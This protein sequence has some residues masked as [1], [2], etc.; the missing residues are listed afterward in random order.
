MKK[1]FLLVA[2]LCVSTVSFSQN[3]FSLFNKA[4]DFF[5]LLGEAKFDSAH[6]YFDESEQTKITADNLKQ[7]WTNMTTALGKPES[8]EAVQS[9][10]QDGFFAVTMEGKFANAD[11][12]FIIAFNKEEKIIGLLVA[13]KAATYLVPSYAADTTKYQEQSTYVQTPGHQLAAVVTTPRN[14]TNF[15]MVVLVHGS[16]SGDMDETVGPNKPF[17]DI[18]LG[19]ASKG[20]GSIR[21]VKRSLVY[22]GEFNKAFTVK[23]EVIDD[24]VAALAM[25]KTIKGVDQKNIYLFGHN[26]GGMLAPQIAA[27]VSSLNGVIL[28]ATPARKLTD[29]IIS[30]N[31]YFF[32]KIK[33]TTAAAKSQ[34]QA[35]VTEV[36]KSRISKLG[37]LKP[38]SSIIGL[39]A[40]YW[41]NLNAYDQ[42]NAVKKLN[43]R[44]LILQGGYDFQVPELDFNLWKAALVQ[45]KNASFKLYPTL[46]HLLSPQTEIGTSAQYQ[47]LTNVSEDLINDIALWI[48]GQPL[49]K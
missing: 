22:A 8:I 36:E 4:N 16:G 21:Y 34:L 43:K 45:K 17:K 32:D 26:L 6:L 29:L 12:N 39:P 19:L 9:K 41:V 33:D 23:E 35:M 47:I 48:K 46:N 7:F 49:N 24:A 31:Q 3:V 18:A 42:V 13:P 38:D 20:I 5:T 28:A 44:V 15:P 10:V 11:Q 40:A 37:D 2:L 25:A 30:Q 1:A 14:A 27:S